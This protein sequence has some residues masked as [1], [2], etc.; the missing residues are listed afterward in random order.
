MNAY[1]S[2]LGKTIYKRWEKVNFSLEAFPAIA[3]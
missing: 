2:E 3:T 1:F